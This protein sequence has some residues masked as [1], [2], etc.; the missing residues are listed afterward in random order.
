MKNHAEALIFHTA[1]C[2]GASQ[3]AFIAE[4]KSPAR[5][6]LRVNAPE[7][8]ISLTETFIISFKLRNTYRVNSIIYSIKQLPLIKKVLSDS[9]YESSGLKTLANIISIMTEIVNTFIGKFIYMVLMVY[10]ASILYS[11]DNADIFIHIFSLPCAEG[12]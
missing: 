11:S 9:L 6:F 8:R 12:F 4:E 7:W 5:I 2:A 10:M 3:T 1:V